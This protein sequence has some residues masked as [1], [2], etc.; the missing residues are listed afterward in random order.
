MKIHLLTVGKIENKHLKALAA[1]YEE[2]IRHYSAID[3]EAI[4]PEKIKTLSSKEILQREGEKLAQK[5]P[6][7]G[8]V[9]ILDS[10]G[11]EYSSEE[12]ADFFRSLINRSVKQATFIIGGPLGLADAA[13]K[14]K[15]NI[16]LGKITLPHELAAVV[17][18]EQIYRA[19]TIL[20]GEKYHK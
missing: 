16:S 20:R 8:E 15:K 1:L 11:E 18:L 3:I 9:I 2:R 19:Q 14:G 5:L 7:S 6:K 13:K 17:L 10:K 4:K 12:L